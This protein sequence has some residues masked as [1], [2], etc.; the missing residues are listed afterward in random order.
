MEKRE[1]DT[2]FLL[3]WIG[4]KYV[5]ILF[6]N[7]KAISNKK[8]F[9]IIS[10]YLDIKPG[11]NRNTFGLRWHLK[12]LI[13]CELSDFSKRRKQDKTCCVCLCC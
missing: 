5:F 4:K 6:I 11:V 10:N 13:K 8:Y 3:I 2:Y 12:V 7:E 1:N 9:V